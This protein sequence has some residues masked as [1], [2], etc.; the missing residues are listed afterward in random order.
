MQGHAFIV[1]YSLESVAAA[2]DTSMCRDC[3][4]RHHMLDSRLVQRT[5]IVREYM[6]FSR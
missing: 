1:F 6:E 3:A 2:D 5:I 4:H